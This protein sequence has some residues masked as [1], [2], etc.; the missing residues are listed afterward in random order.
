MRRNNNLYEISERFKVPASMQAPL[1]SM[2]FHAQC[3][4]I[5]AA[6]VM[7]ASAILAV[8]ALGVFGAM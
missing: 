5:K 7:L 1:E 6:L 2:G 4:R 3:R 8:F